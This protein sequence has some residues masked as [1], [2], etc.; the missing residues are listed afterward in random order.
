[1]NMAAMFFFGFTAGGLF[2]GVLIWILMAR[3]K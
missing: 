2:N 1:M 3:R